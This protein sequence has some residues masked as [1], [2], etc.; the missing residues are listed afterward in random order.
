MPI[1]L[2]PL[3]FVDAMNWEAPVLAGSMK[4]LFPFIL[5]TFGDCSGLGDL[6]PSNLGLLFDDALA[7]G[8]A[9][10]TGREARL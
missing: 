10:E 3:W 4:H 6:M 1:I 7:W 2:E 5:P 8:W 9:A